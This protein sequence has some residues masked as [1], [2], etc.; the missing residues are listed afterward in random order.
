[1]RP[2]L[3]IDKKENIKN[4]LV[5]LGQIKIEEMSRIIKDLSNKL[6]RMET[7][8]RRLDNIKL[9]QFRIPFNPHQVLQRE[10][11]V[12]DKPIHA[13]LKNQKLIDNFMNEEE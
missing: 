2:I 8:R 1:L 13:P 9:N 12:E 5:L 10:K 6:D 11:I 4:K 3:G 7:K